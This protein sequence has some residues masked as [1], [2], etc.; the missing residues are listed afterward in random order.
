[1]IKGLLGLFKKKYKKSSVKRLLI[2]LLGI[3]I[4]VFIISFIII[5]LSNLILIHKINQI[6]DFQIDA[7]KIIVQIMQNYNQAVYRAFVEVENGNYREAKVFFS[8]NI[9]SSIR[10]IDK[11]LKEKRYLKSGDLINL[12]KT[13]LD[14]KIYLNSYSTI[15]TD[16]LKKKQELSIRKT[17]VSDLINSINEEVIGLKLDLSKSIVE[18]NINSR[19]KPYYNQALTDTILLSYKIK[20]F[21]MDLIKHID[22]ASNGIN[23]GFDIVHYTSKLKFEID[24]IF[25]NVGEFSERQKNMINLLDSIEENS[26]KCM[27]LAQETNATYNDSNFYYRVIESM[28]YGFNKEINYKV[29][30]LQN[31]LIILRNRIL[32]LIIGIIGLSVVFLFFFIFIIKN[33][34]F[35]PFSRFL[36]AIQ[37]ASKGK[38]DI[39]IRL[40]TDDEFNTLAEHF[41]RMSTAIVEREN[42]L[43][44]E[45]ELVENKSRELESLK[46]YIEDI[47]HASPNA[48]FSV[49]QNLRILFLNKK[50]IELIGRENI[51][52]K[53]LTDIKCVIT[54]YLND[55]KEVLI[56]KEGR[57][58]GKK[59]IIFPGSNKRIV[60]LYIYPLHT[61]NGTGAVIEV[62]DVTERIV[63]EEKM[64][65][66]QKMET[67]GL[68]AGGFAHD[69]N[70]LLTGLMGYV[71]LAMMS[72]NQDKIMNYLKRVKDISL[73]ASKLVQQ[74][75]LF[76]RTGA[77][78]KEVI[79]IGVIIEG[80]LNMIKSPIKRDI[81]LI[82]EIEK[83][84]NIYADASQMTQ[85]ILN[86][87][88][89]SF[90]A[91][92]DKK[93]GYVKI[94]AER[95]KGDKN[96][97]II[98]NGNRDYIK[99]SIEDNGI[100][101]SED[102]KSRIFE[103]FFTTKTRGNIKGTG[104]GL[105]IVYRVIKNHEGEIVVSSNEGEG[106]RFEI[107]L[108]VEKNEKV[109]Q[110]HIVADNS[111][112]GTGS[113][114]LVDDEDMVRE[115]GK[116]ILESL[117]YEVIALK[118]GKECIDFFVNRK[119][120]VDLIIMDL[121]MPE[122]DGPETL[123][124]LSVIGVKVPVLIASGYITL[125][126]S[127][128]KNYDYIKGMIRKPYSVTDISVKLAKILSKNR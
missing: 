5:V 48:I 69:F 110:R 16:F 12:N 15:F 3:N 63:M 111:M 122:M 37:L 104:L 61:T 84:L 26:L 83:G 41:N 117:G 50:A 28:E 77:G 31:R 36:Y 91:V 55:I 124:K 14:L 75:L 54:E 67:V 49:D 21:K 23:D 59:E 90:E 82:K 125:D 64:L 81:H 114:L 65:E 43:I 57:V 98:L 38:R 119:K 34:I 45:K 85:A 118:S 68:L 73:H 100:G 56:K 27:R 39:Y 107:Y 53:K 60:N 93:D 105:S 116:E 109:I 89:N 35:N 128:L 108:P 96:E 13:F 42:E 25:L 19:L 106:T 126:M 52:D 10:T 79:D 74:I 99:I 7:N 29:S 112:S 97:K 86:L 2:S 62:E 44:R 72:K 95:F 8:D 4:T 70:N 22:N 92:N 17:A 78:K 46:K 30:R 6:V 33:R 66:S 123:K 1:M 58:L 101:M 127:Y 80:A 103:P 94:K 76:S 20:K 102:V 87:I 113:I 9:E 115:V 32:F 120:A 88:I 47:V 24:S 11:Y 51:I 18:S 40:D 71:E 121:V